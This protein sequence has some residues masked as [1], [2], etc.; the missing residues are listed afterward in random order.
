M[1]YNGVGGMTE[2]RAHKIAATLV[3]QF[4]RERFFAISLPKIEDLES[5]ARI[6]EVSF[7]CTVVWNYQRSKISVYCPEL[8]VE[9][10]SAVVMVEPSRE[11]LSS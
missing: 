4:S 1:D 5:L 2:E 11:R 7:G 3:K 9:Q 10:D 8:A 6:L